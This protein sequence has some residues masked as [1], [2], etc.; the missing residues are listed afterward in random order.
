MPA[1]ADW[2]HL[3]SPVRAPCNPPAAASGRRESGWQARDARG[4]LLDRVSQVGEFVKRF[5]P[6]IDI[7]RCHDRNITK[8]PRGGESG[9]PLGLLKA[10]ELKT[11]DR[12]S[13]PSLLACLFGAACATQAHAASFML[14]R[15]LTTGSSRAIASSSERTFS[16]WPSCRRSAALRQSAF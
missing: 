14:P 9:S 11:K 1:A 2:R 7:F 10:S 12:I 3:H 5:L 4:R 15:T 8:N 13:R 6:G 16:D